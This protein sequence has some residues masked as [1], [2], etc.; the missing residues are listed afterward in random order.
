MRQWARSLAVLVAGAA[1]A[2]PAGAQTTIPSF[3]SAYPQTP[4]PNDW[5]S[6]RV[7]Y[8]GGRL[9]Y[10]SDGEG[11][12]IP[13][14]SYA[15]YKYGQ[16]AL[17]AVPEV[18][19]L[20]SAAGDN[21]ARIQQALD[22]IGTRTPDGNGFRGALVLNPGTYEIRGTLRVNRSG[23]VL[24]GSGDDSS[25]TTNTILRAT[26][27]TPH[28]R[29]VIVLGSG[30]S[31]WVESSTRTNITTQRVT[32][33][34]RSFSV[35]STAGLAV[36]DAIVVRHPSTQAWLNAVD[37][38][39][40][41]SDAD[42]AVNQ[43]DIVY[44]RRITQ[45]A[46]SVLTIDVPVYNHLDRALSQSYV[47][48]VTSSHIV[49]AG[50]ENLR[51]DIVTAG[52][53][54]ENHAW[55]GV[56][57]TGAHDSWVRNITALHF[58][59][60]GVRVDG[61]VRVTVADSRALDPVAIRTGSRMYNFDLERRAQMVLFTNC[62]ATQG[63]HAFISNGVSVSSGIVFHRG[64]TTN[65][66]GSEGGHRHWV[67]G[68]LFDNIV[69]SNS[70]QLLLIN[71]GDFGTSHG[72]G[73]AHSTIWKFNSELLVQK[74]PTAQ[75]Y[76]ISN[77]GHFRSSTYFPGPR[78]HEEIRSGNLV[79]TSLYEAQLCERLEGS[80]PGQSV[81]FGVAAGAVTASANDGN[82][83]AN[84]VD[85]NLG[86]RW[87]AQGDGQWI[88]FDLGATRTLDFVKVAWY[89]GDTRTST[90]DIQV[91]NSAGGPWSTVQASAQS[92]GGLGLE[93]HDFA[94]VTG[95]FVRLLGHGNSLN[96]WNSITE[97]EI[98]G[99]N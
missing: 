55:S 64:R 48:E 86:T 12:R 72:W 3:C 45:I 82:V 79:P 61:S 5:Q 76:G 42:W 14:Y 33:G 18:M 94:N 92:Q 40:V 60:A 27:D 38:G 11:N 57:V 28:Q 54:D 81:K 69:E 43:I 51:V 58:G 39:G 85:A 32:V 49:E 16:A 96:L 20:S 26:G 35:A 13:D 67:T 78:G 50:V 75:N 23:V 29:P 84:T 30:N 41:V 15:G 56:Q 62:E 95:R 25:P 24:R 68:V 59:F 88:Q 83:P 47:A 93:T 21:T 65:G 4:G 10:A 98:W 36:G 73:A 90:F 91:S 7:F 9:T 89:Q 37:G 63:R 44:Y 2:V 1:C 70:A 71:R 87:S 99:Q 8:S 80:S 31:D 77:S 19:R 22:Q 46:G 97:V 34:S 66:G 74:P 6:S 53:E 52:G 17:P